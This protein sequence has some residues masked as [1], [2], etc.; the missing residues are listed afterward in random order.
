MYT[1]KLDN[2]KFGGADPTFVKEFTWC[3]Y[4]YKYYTIGIC[5]LCGQPVKVWVDK[6]IVMGEP[7]F[8]K[9]M[10]N[11]DSQADSANPNELSQRFTN[12]LA[13][14]VQTIPMTELATAP[15]QVEVI[16]SQPGALPRRWLGTP[17]AST[18]AQ[19]EEATNKG[20]GTQKAAAPES[21]AALLAACGLEHHEKTFK[22]EG[23]TLDTLLSSM[24]QGEEAVKSDLR[25][26][27]LTLGEC[28][29]L[30]NHLGASK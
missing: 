14:Q 25:E 29:Q 18:G 20:A 26:L 23:Y 5:G 19:D 24:E 28:R 3:N 16:V 12:Q 6:C 2:M 13:G 27:K 10:A 9:D 8:D 15:Q 30:I 7:T 1:V 4:I 22:A 17:A 21:L 11:R